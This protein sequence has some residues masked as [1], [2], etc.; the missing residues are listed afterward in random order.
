MSWFTKL[1][2]KAEESPKDRV[3]LITVLVV[4]ESPIVRKTFE[5]M[6]GEKPYRVS[7]D[8]NAA[9]AR[10]RLTEFL[11]DVVFIDTGLSEQ[12]CPNLCRFIR[13]HPK[14]KDTA[15]FLLASTFDPFD[16]ELATR[17]GANGHFMKPLESIK[18]VIDTVNAVVGR[19]SRTS[20]DALPDGRA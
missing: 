3:K 7:C 4:D 1:F 10:E 9:A 12:G 18:K 15:V 19:R 20:L 6:F 13:G 16:E 5:M 17:V 2:E 8:S 14:L 11:P